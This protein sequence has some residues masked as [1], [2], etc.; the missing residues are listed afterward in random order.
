[1]GGEGLRKTHICDAQLEEHYQE[2]VQAKHL[3]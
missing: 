3:V 2:H 1:M